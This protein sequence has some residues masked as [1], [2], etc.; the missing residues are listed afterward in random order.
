VKRPRRWS[1]RAC[2]K[3]DESGVASA[4]PVEQRMQATMVRPEC[5]RARPPHLAGRA[6]VLVRIEKKS[7]QPRAPPPLL[8]KKIRA[9]PRLVCFVTSRCSRTVTSCSPTGES[10][11]RAVPL[12]RSMWTFL[13]RRVRNVFRGQEPN[14]G[15]FFSTLCRKSACAAQQFSPQNCDSL[16]SFASRLTYA[17]RSLLDKSSYSSP[18]ARTASPRFG[19]ENCGPVAVR[20]LHSAPRAQLVASSLRMLFHVFSRYMRVSERHQHNASLLLDRLVTASMRVHT[21]EIRRGVSLPRSE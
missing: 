11:L 6:R 13:P 7:N 2:G 1:G 4:Q 14:R 12:R 16:T 9:R 10:V 17:S 8:K 15:L 19:T 20:N 18:S 21:P 3:S 5:P